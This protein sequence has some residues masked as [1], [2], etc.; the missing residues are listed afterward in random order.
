MKRNSV[1]AWLVRIYLILWSVIILLPFVML[2]LTSTKT[3]A[4]FYAGIWSLPKDFFSSV[5][6]NYSAAW[7]KGNIGNNFINTLI[8]SSVALFLSLFLSSM[9]SYAI[10]RRK[11]R[12]AGKLST[13]FLLGL[14]IPGMAGLTPMF[15]G[16]RFAH[17]FNTR[18]ILIILYA[19]MELPF[20]TFVMTSFFRSVPSEMEE[21]AAIDGA[22][23]WRTF[24]QIILPLVRPAFVSAGI[25][26]FLDFWSEYMY[27]LMFIVDPAKKT[28]SMG[29]LTFKI[30][31]G[32]KIDWGVTA[33]AC[34]I[35]I[36]PVLILYILFQ[37]KIVGGLTSGS[38]KG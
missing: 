19:A 20:C 17:L 32:F 33:A 9:V 34:V 18:T 5:V 6:S 3:S 35:F 36:A 25:F 7:A 28:I 8:V 22:S 10:A 31:S 23:P 12:C 24:G 38:V 4:E 15:I 26:C 29:M 16:A 30:I 11:L 21:A 1:S 2:L 37:R 13:L 14:L 27:G